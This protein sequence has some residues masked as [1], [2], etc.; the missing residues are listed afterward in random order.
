MDLQMPTMSGIEAAKRIRDGEAGDAVKNT[1]IVAITAFTSD[2]NLQ[3][4]REVGMD[5]FLAKPFDISK[6]K[7]EII[8]AFHSKV[9]EQA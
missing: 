1:R 4:S 3:A 9:V 6:I 8:H 2:A 7:M 5:A